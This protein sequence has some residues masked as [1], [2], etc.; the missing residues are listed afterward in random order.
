MPMLNGFARVIKYI[1]NDKDHCNVLEI[2][3]GSF[4][5]GM[6]QGYCRIISAVTGK[7]EVGFF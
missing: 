1:I 2:T 6:K 3:E 4:E 7:C 5:K